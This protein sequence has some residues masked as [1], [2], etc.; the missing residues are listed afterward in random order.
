MECLNNG[1]GE[2]LGSVE[3]AETFDRDAGGTVKLDTEEK[4]CTRRGYW[5]LRR[6][7]DILL[8]LLALAVLAPALLLLA[9]IIYIDDPHGSPIYS[10]LPVLQIV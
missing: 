1:R 10:L 7:Q 5:L 2:S 9:L 4:L 8:S 3:K 6:G